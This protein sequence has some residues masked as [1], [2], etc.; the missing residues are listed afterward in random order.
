MLQRRGCCVKIYV[1][2]KLIATVACVGTILSLCIFSGC[3]GEAKVLFELNEDGTYTVSG[4]SGNKDKLVSY[5]IPQTYSEDGVNFAPVTKIGDSAFYGC[6]YLSDVVIPDSV[7]SIGN[8]AFTL[9]SFEEIVIPDSVTEI[10][11]SA[12]AMCSQLREIVIPESVQT[13]EERAFYCCQKLEKVVIKAPLTGILRDT[14]SNR[15]VTANGQVYMST[16]LT[17]IYLPSTIERIR[18]SAF[19]G[20]FYLTDVYFAGSKEQWDNIKFYNLVENTSVAAGYEE[21]ECIFEDTFITN[22]EVHFNSNF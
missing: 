20:N 2:K 8:L 15:Y 3:S 19:G 21:V 14:F 4:V 7:T 5:E 17:E 18:N 9:C 11:W 1:M 22:P 6:S 12:F 10:G 13:V 16:S